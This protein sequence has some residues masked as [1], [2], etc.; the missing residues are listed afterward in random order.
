M[1]YFITNKDYEKLISKDLFPDITILNEK[2]GIKLFY[3]LLGNKKTL[4]VDLEATGLDAYTTT[5]LLYGIGTR[6]IQFM[7]DWTINVKPIFT[8]LYKRK[9]LIL[10]HNLKYDIK[11]IKVNTGILLRKLYDTMIVEQRLFMKSGY[12]FSYAD[13]IERYLKKYIFKGTRNEFIGAD[14]NTFKINTKHLY[15]LKTDLVEL[16]DIKETQ[17]IYIKKFNMEFLL[18]GVELPLIHTIAEAEL[19]GFDFNIKKWRERLEKEKLER[20]ELQCNL[21]FIVR[22]LRD[23]VSHH[24]LYKKL[25]P[26][27]TLGG[28]KYNNLR[29]VN[30]MYDIFKPDGT[31]TS[32]NIFGEPSTHRDITGVKKKVQFSPNNINYNYKKEIVHIFAALEQPMIKPDETFAIPQL[33]NKGKLIGSVNDFTIKE[34]FLQK[35][36]LAKPNSMLNEFIEGI[37]KHS[38][39]EKSI[40]TYGENFIQHLNPITGRL[41]TAFRQCNADTGRFQSGGGTSEPDKPNFQNIPAK[42]E[43]RE[44]FTVDTNKY[45]VLTADYS[46]AELIVMASH[47]QDFK[48][49]SLS[50][51]DMHSHMATKCWRNIFGFRASRLL[52]IFNKNLVTKTRELVEEYNNNV[53]KFKTYIVSKETKDKRTEFKPMTFE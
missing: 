37:L 31:T 26:K 53:N 41:H 17:Q 36:I 49:I 25:D 30:P 39:L 43:Y 21:D 44:C 23:F 7:F 4:S 18:Y 27:I 32:L 46:G 48:L 35:Y 29:K 28:Q 22:D 20:F 40:S 6:N 11:L 9:I 45:S 52:N 12:K 47:A 3:K 13:L 1:I 16:F 14:I 38:K 5:P 8:Y 34:E 2:E 33:N 19:E 24:S 10:G 50:K 15:Y 42:I 51:G